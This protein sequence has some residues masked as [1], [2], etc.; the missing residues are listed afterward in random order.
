MQNTFGGYDPKIFTK[1]VNQDFYCPICSSKKLNLI[2]AASDDLRNAQFVVLYAVRRVSKCG[3]KRIVI[4]I[5]II[6]KIRVSVL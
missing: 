1:S 3:R 4:I 2:K 6:K 5:K